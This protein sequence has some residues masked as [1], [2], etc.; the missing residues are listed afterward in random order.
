MLQ[1]LLCNSVQDRHP[2]GEH[3]GSL[4]DYLVAELMNITPE[5]TL[6]FTLLAFVMS[7]TPGPNNIMVMAT[8]LNFGL[9]KTLI[10]TL[11]VCLGCAFMLFSAGLGL[12]TLFVHYPL[13]QTV[14]KYLG[15]AYLLWLAWQIAR[16]G[17]VSGS[18]ASRR[19]RPI[20]FWEA[21]VLQWVNPKAW[22]MAM[23]AVSTYL[24]TQFGSKDIFVYA[25]IFAG[26]SLPCV[27]IWGIFGIGLKQLLQTP[28]L[29]RKF[30]Y[31]CALL[32]VL[33]LYPLIT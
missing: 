23:G 3:S 19:A 29:V 2:P 32:L 1:R 26:I 10:H 33:S 27:G 30:N 17:P 16:S 22:M 18:V 24:P 25:V 7:V 4:L 31:V 15:I 13:L 20:S 11:G 21:A 6:A 12:H 9:R 5:Q 28:A 14:V 8:G